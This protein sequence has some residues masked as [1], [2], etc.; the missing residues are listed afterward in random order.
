MKEHVNITDT[1]LSVNCWRLCDTMRYS[2]L[3]AVI[4][5]VTV[6]AVAGAVL[7]LDGGGDDPGNITYVLNGGENSSENP[8]SYVDMPEAFVL[9]DPYSDMY[10]FEGWY[11][12]STFDDGTEITELPAHY[13]DDLFL[14]AK[15]SSL[16]GKGFTLNISGAQYSN[17]IWYDI[18]GEI[19]YRYIWESEDEYF[20]SYDRS[21]STTWTDPFTHVEKTETTEDGDT[22]WTGES[23]REWTYVGTQTVTTAIG[24][25]EC[26]VFES[27]GEKQYIGDDWIPYLITYRDDEIGS[28][29]DLTY[30]FVSLLTEFEPTESFE[31]SIISDSGI[32][33]KGEGVYT[34]GSEV[35]L[36]ATV[37]TDS[38]FKGWYDNTGTLLSTD[39]SYTTDPL[40]HDTIILAYCDELASY[41]IYPEDRM[42]FSSG[43]VAMNDDTTW[44]VT[45]T[46]YPGTIPAYV[47]GSAPTY[48]FSEPGI[49]EIEMSGTANDE[50]PLTRTFTVVV[51][52]N[53]ER[54]FTWKYDKPY[55]YALSIPLSDYIRYKEDPTYRG[56]MNAEHNLSFVTYEDTTIVKLAH[57]LEEKSKYMSTND[58]ANFLLAFVDCIPYDYE[59]YYGNYEY[60]R[61]PIET[62][63]DSTGDCEDTSILYAALGK[64]MNYDVCLFTFPGHMAAGVGLE[65]YSYTNIHNIPSYFT[66][67]TTGTDYYFCET[68]AEKEN[69]Y[70]V[71]K[72]EVY[73]TYQQMYVVI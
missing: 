16:V 55:E 47:T 39:L 9:R 71:G 35:T 33:V 25:K 73:S 21:V 17:G 38:S 6:V 57:D 72:N 23:E 27:E 29:V 63:Y 65:D 15:W 48:A 11:T 18:S 43:T 51:Y 52:G 41:Y 24:E 10:L 22:Y 14:Y 56:Q 64:A 45:N 8:V 28:S 60:W 62:L 34:P 40:D 31:I 66:D 26:S 1:K 44:T 59:E 37:A 53:I 19:T 20:I 70:P 7:Y 42:A 58:R 69:F 2:V 68:T 61:F 4:A 46:S 36:E 67:E 32:T 13:S 30:T 54:T 50:I 5:M 49:Y 3:A 12:T